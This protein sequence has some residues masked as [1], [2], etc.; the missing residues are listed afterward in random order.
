MTWFQWCTLSSTLLR[1]PI[2]S[3]LACIHS[4]PRGA[5]VVARVKKSHDDQRLS[6][7]PVSGA[8]DVDRATSASVSGDHSQIASP[9]TF[10]PFT[11]RSSNARNSTV[12]DGETIAS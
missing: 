5:G 1:G 10:V 12:F 8:A 2:A 11:T 9:R 4:S 6:S 3:A 7:A